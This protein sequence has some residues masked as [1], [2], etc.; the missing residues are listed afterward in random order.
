MWV[1]T[2]R[3]ERVLF[4]NIQLLQSTM[5]LPIIPTTPLIRTSYIHRRRISIL[6]YQE[7]DFTAAFL[8]KTAE[9]P[10]NKDDG[11]QTGVRRSLVAWAVAADDMEAF[12]HLTK[13]YRYA[14]DA[15]LTSTAGF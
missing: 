6:C 14:K 2:S 10:P 15:Q 13:L 9:F 11:T 7:R 1:Q 3:H 5:T 12:T 4:P 8:E